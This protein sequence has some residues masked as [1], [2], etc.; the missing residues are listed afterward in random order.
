[1]TTILSALRI[2]V[3]LCAITI[4]VLRFC[5]KRLS[6]ASWTICSER[7]SSADVASS[8][9]RILGSRINALAIQT[10]CFCPPLS[11]APFSPKIV[12]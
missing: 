11:R 7:L 4:V 8:R 2:V 10:R 3:S 9:I 6:R 12:S 5:T 1:M